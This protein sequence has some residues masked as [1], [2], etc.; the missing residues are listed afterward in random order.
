M[1]AALTVYAMLS[2]I[3]LPPVTQTTLPTQTPLD[4]LLTAWLDVV[5]VCLL[6]LWSTS[7]EESLLPVLGFVLCGE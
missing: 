4:A 1:T 6:L 2:P 5:C 7:I 3:Y